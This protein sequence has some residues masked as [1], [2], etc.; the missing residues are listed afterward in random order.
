MEIK[1]FEI[2]EDLANWILPPGMATVHW[3]LAFL[4][5]QVWHFLS[6]IVPVQ[7]CYQSNA[8]ILS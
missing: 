2:L 5:K 8:K 7:N 1:L 6:T 3:V 4:Y